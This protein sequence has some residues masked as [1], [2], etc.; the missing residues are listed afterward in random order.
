MQGE[1]KVLVIEESV[2]RGVRVK[3]S[4]LDHTKIANIFTSSFYDKV[5]QIQP[6]TY[7]C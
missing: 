3:Y 2:Q 6:T 5:G 1:V 4:S 7:F